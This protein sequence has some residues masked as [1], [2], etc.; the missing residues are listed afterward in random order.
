MVC[1]L[2]AGGVAESALKLTQLSSGLLQWA[3]R[4]WNV[5]LTALLRWKW[6]KLWGSLGVWAVIAPGALRARPPPRGYWEQPG[7]VRC[8]R[9]P[10]SHPQSKAGG[11]W[12]AA[13]ALHCR[14][15]QTE[16]V[17]SSAKT[18]VFWWRYCSLY[19]C[20]PPNS[21][22]K[23][24]YHRV[25]CADMRHISNHFALL[26][27]FFFNNSACAFSPQRTQRQ[28]CKEQVGVDHLPN[29]RRYLHFHRA[30]SKARRLI[31]ERPI[32]D[33]HFTTPWMMR[34]KAPVIGRQNGNYT[35]FSCSHS[36]LLL[37]K[38]LPCCER[39]EQEKNKKH[40]CSAEVD[41]DSQF[42]ANE[43]HLEVTCHRASW[44]AGRLS[45]WRGWQLH[46]ILLM[47]ERRPLY[48]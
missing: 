6:L 8:N 43:G 25:C 19:V 39:R 37:G 32:P 28:Q 12:I 45:G 10:S 41:R 29:A 17:R 13:L 21:Y 2:G 7:A 46:F 34:K 3:W 48:F 31:L 23:Q 27:F 33:P 42:C 15:E 26:F 35:R 30:I 36:D 5:S 4:G 40:S 22:C 38:K 20:W 47:E 14:G 9:R 1:G 44:I 18:L 16:M 11:V 24:T